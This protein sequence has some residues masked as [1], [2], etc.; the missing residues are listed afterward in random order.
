VS[1]NTRFMPVPPAAV[2]AALADAGGYGYWVV[3]SKVIREADATWPAPG[4]K[5]HHTVG[6]GP[7]EFTDHTESIEAVAPRRLQL[8][9]KARP[10]GTA[11]VTLEMTPKDG[12]TIVR[13]TENPDGAFRPLALIPPLQAFSALRN[14]ES[15]MRLEELAM[16]AARA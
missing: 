10:L 14:A 4:S 16:R 3:G 11:K 12:G 2:W 15:L 8:R 7:F 6:L 9:A 5:I 13:I 1:T